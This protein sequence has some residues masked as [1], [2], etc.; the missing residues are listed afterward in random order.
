MHLIVAQDITLSFNLSKVLTWVIIGLIAGFL[1][2]FVVR[3]RGFNVVTNVITGLIGA[4][5][6]GILVTLL[7]I[8]TPAFLAGNLTIP[9]FDIAVAFVGAVI[10]LVILSLFYR[11]R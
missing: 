6:G 11:R 8:P 1:A 9:Y 10:V 7:K 5:V 4:V 2:G 3:G